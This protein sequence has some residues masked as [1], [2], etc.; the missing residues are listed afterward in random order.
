MYFLLIFILSINRLNTECSNSNN[1]DKNTPSDHNLDL[2]LGQNSATRELGF[3]P[4]A[5][6]AGQMEMYN[7]RETL[8]RLSDQTHLHPVG[9]S[10]VNYESHRYGPQTRSI[11]PS[12]FHMLCP[13]LVDS[14]NHQTQQSS[15]AMAANTTVASSG[16]PQHQFTMKQPAAPPYAQTWLYNSGYSF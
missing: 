4:M 8:V 1:H 3:R 14:W 6:R 2:S 15:R 11:D 9:S 12:M 5:S 7:N 13:P 16:F 10:E